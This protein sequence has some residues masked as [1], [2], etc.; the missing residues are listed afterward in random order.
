[1]SSSTSAGWRLPWAPDDSTSFA[2]SW[3]EPDLAQF[4]G[5]LHTEAAHERV[6]G[7]AE[8]HDDRPEHTGVDALGGSKEAGG[9]ERACH[10][11]RLGHELSHDHL[12][13]RRDEQR[14]EDRHGLG[15]RRA[16][17]RLDR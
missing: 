8:Q 6:G 3:R 12:D 10:R 17:D 7:S 13:H 11:D 5:G 1:M 4:L 14:Q 15:V 16:D 9:A 2:S